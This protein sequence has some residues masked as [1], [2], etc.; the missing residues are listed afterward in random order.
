MADFRNKAKG[1]SNPTQLPANAEEHDL[2]LNANKDWWEKNPM[3][4]DFSQ[5]LD[6]KEE[7]SKEFYQEI[8]K[9]FF[10]ASADYAPYKKLPFETII[11]YNF[12]A[13]KNILEIGVGNGSHA[14]LLASHCKSFT[15]IDLTEYAIESTK[16]RM[17][18]FGIAN[19]TIMQM[20][21]EQLDFPDNSFDYVWSWGVIHHSANTQKILEE[22]DRVLKPGGK[23]V[24]M[25]YYRSFWYYYVF[26]G[27]FHGVLKG[28]LFKEKSFHKVAQ[29]AMDGAIAR[30]YKIHEWKKMCELA[31]LKVNSAEVAGTKAE[32]I[33]IPP[34][35]F[36]NKILKY[37]P[38][39]ISRILTKNMKMG[40][41]LISHLSKAD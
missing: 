35:K 26:A 31:H 16:K 7:F 39:S 30:F 6:S 1:F 14:Q 41:L 13:D 12:I 23:A 19:A 5:S 21:A 24:T 4:Y 32:I 34:G 8:D 2:W 10:Y 22:I 3:R 36:K 40:Y 38:G 25:V 28:Y 20:N 27:F 17:A 9:R 11:D 29:R 37:F 18:I 15:G 33:L